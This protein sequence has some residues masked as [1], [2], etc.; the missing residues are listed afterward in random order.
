MRSNSPAWKELQKAYK[1]PEMI[2]VQ[3]ENVLTK[4]VPEVSQEARQANQVPLK[5]QVNKAQIRREYRQ[6]F[7]NRGNESDDSEYEQK[8][9]Q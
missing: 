4:E 6:F 8:N 1:T 3:M 9:L 2:R 5:I 7:N